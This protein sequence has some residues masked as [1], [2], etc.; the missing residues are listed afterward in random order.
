M[1]RQRQLGASFQ[2][3]LADVDAANNLLW[4]AQSE[5]DRLER[6]TTFYGLRRDLYDV[7]SAQ[8]CG[9]GGPQKIQDLFC[10]QVTLMQS[11]APKLLRRLQD[12]H[13]TTSSEDAV[14][15]AA[16]PAA[17][18]ATFVLRDGET[19]SLRAVRS[20]DPQALTAFLVDLPYASY[21]ARYPK[22]EGS[23]QDLATDTIFH[24][25]HPDPSRRRVSL[26]LQDGHG[27]I[28]G[29][30]DYHERGEPLMKTPVE[31][32]QAQG[33][34]SPKLS[35]KT[36]EID[37]VLAKVLQ[38]QQLGQHLLQFAIKHASA[39]G[40]EQIVAVVADTNTASLNMLAKIGAT[41]GLPLLDFGYKLY[42]LKSGPDVS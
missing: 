27:C 6:S 22:V 41:H 5:Y 4:A 7:Q 11:H 24:A 38:G 30:L 2:A 34:T 36:C 16:D 28:V 35:L 33:L 31:F 39:A 3:T 10:A 8:G 17:I 40:Y 18:C 42:L 9:P 12:W 15:V 20:D 29:L 23:R 37:V 32:A 19:V 25:L 14:P 1:K 13:S 26:V 21:R